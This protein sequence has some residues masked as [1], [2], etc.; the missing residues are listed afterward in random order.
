MSEAGRDPQVVAAALLGDPRMVEACGTHDVQTVIRLM[1]SRGASLRGLASVTGMSPSRVYEYEAGDRQAYGFEIFER[2]SDGFRIPGRYWRLA[3]RPW[4]LAD[5]TLARPDSIDLDRWVPSRT[6]EAVSVFTRTDLMLDRRE[7][8]KAIATLAVGMPL[9]ECVERWLSPEHEEP[10]RSA[11]GCIGSEE[12]E[13]IEQAAQLFRDWDDHFGGGLRRKAVIGQLNEVA[14]LLRD[15]HPQE[16]ARRLFRVMAHLAE[17]AAMMSWDSGIHATAQRYYILALRASKEAK[18]YAFG[19]NILAS[20]ARQLLYMGRP[21]DALELVRLAGDGASK[22]H[23]PGA[24]WSMLH[25]REAWAYANLGRVQAFKRATGKAEDA[26]AAA[27]RSEDPHWIRYFDAAELAG[28]TGGRMLDLAQKNPEETAHAR[29]AETMIDKALKLRR[30]ESMRSF[31]LD[32]TGLAQTYFLQRD[33]EQAISAGHRAIDLAEQT[34]SDRVR[35]Q[36]QGLY[37][38]AVA[39]RSKPDVREFTDRLASALNA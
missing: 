21:D 30:P 2:L 27:D 36:L 1:R 11:L 8:S 12:V 3:D 39:H 18:E 22:G 9:I 28:T 13:R 16:I 31:S 17:T 5:I 26:L 23:A 7:A 14:D 25:T 20:M 4:E 10:V 37:Q 29:E 32:Q 15:T 34:Q 19:A 38:L 35:V 6:V 33:L 24:V